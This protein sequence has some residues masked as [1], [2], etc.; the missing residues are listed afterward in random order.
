MISG[1]LLKLFL[2]VEISPELFN[3]QV[4]IIPKISASI[5]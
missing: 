1:A 4:Q 2:K 3:N 5:H